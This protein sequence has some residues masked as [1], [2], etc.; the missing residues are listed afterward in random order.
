MKYKA[1]D[2]VKLKSLSA[3]K[4]EYDCNEHGYIMSPIK[5]NPDMQ[6]TLRD[7]EIRKDSVLTIRYVTG[8][9]YHFEGT[10]FNWPHEIVDCSLEEYERK[11]QEHKNRPVVLDMIL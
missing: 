8:C 4:K 3:F 9:A 2:K 1:G 6:T 10:I 5:I 11:Q 7:I